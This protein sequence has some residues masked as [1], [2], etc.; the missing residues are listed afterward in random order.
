MESISTD[1]NTQ[2]TPQLLSMG[3]KDSKRLLEVYVKRSLSLNDGSQCP[4][5]HE[6]RSRKWVALT[7]RK[8]RSRK[9]SS[10]TSLNLTSQASVSDEDIRY[11]PVSEPPM[12]KKETPSEKKHKKWRVKGSLRRND[13]SNAS[14]KSNSKPKKKFLLLGKEEGGRST[15][16][17]SPQ[18]STATDGN[19]HLN[20]QENLENSSMEKKDREGKKTK[21][22]T[23]WK[24]FLNWFS[25]GNSEKEQDH[26]RTE[27]Q[28]PLSHPSTPQI[29]CLPLAD[30]LS[31]SDVNLRRSK[32]SK[33]KSL[34]RRSLKWRR[35]EDTATERSVGTVGP[36]NSYYEKMSEELEKIVHE[37]KDSPTDDSATQITDQDGGVNVSQEEVIRKIIEHIKQQGDLI[38]IKLKENSTV[39]AFLNGITYRSFQQM[40]DQYVQS[41]VPSNKTQPPVVA[42]ELVKFAFTLDFTARVA[43]LHRQATGQIMGFG[44][45]YLQE[46]FTHMSENHPHLFDI[47][48]EDWKT[49]NSEQEF[50]SL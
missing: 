45:Q 16:A 34:H 41:E 20:V 47:K 40:A 24:S 11:E 8:P 21:K 27:E 48:A 7:E 38:N 1:Q 36:T 42:P 5:R 6:Q 10:D 23:V 17:L 4:L 29:S 18:T 37:V 9:H 39:T 46:R 32:S 3:E 28:L 31:K 26:Q 30:T 33:K 12:D 49:Q 19:M 44:N 35:N 43:N 25:K 22:P 50:I 15:D 14:Q 13:G 2:P